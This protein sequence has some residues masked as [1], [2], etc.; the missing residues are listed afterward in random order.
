MILSGSRESSKERVDP[1]LSTN[2]V[3]IKSI[4]LFKDQ[5]DKR[6]LNKGVINSPV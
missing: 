1:D 4:L 6:I 2:T 3:V 5:K